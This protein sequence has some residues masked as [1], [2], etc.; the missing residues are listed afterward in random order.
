MRKLLLF[1]IAATML[2]GGLYLLVGELFVASIIYF[3]YV[4]AGAM[5]AT[6]GGYLL[7]TDFVAPL[8]GI[9]TAED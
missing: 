9:K 6:L 8:L 2:V 5:L 7:W 4:I 3:R 1:V